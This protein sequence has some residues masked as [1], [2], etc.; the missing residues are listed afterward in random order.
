MYKHRITKWGFDRKYRKR[1]D[2]PS[3]PNKP[4][5]RKHFADGVSPTASH[6]SSPYSVDGDSST[7]PNSA[8][9]TNWSPRE[10]ST[11]AVLSALQFSGELEHAICRYF[12][13]SFQSRMWVS[14]G[15]GTACRSVKAP[16]NIVDMILRFKHDV[17]FASNYIRHEGTRYGF[18]YLHHGSEKIEG[19]VSAES[20][21]LIADVIEISLLLIKQ[22]RYD[23]VRI[24]LQQ[25]ADM[26]DILKSRSRSHTI[27]RILAQKSKLDALAFEGAALNAWRAIAAC[28]CRELG[29]LHVNTL[30]CYT[31][32]L[33]YFASTSVCAR[34][35]CPTKCDHAKYAE[36]VL[37]SHLLG[38][39]NAYGLVST[40]SMMVLEA[41]VHVCLVRQNYLAAYVLCHE[42]ICCKQ[43][44][45]QNRMLFMALQSISEAKSAQQKSGQADDSLKKLVD[46][47]AW[48][49]NSS[50]AI[51][52][53]TLLLDFL[54]N[55]NK[56]GE[57]ASIE[58][59]RSNDP[60]E[61]IRS[62][63]KWLSRS[64][65]RMVGQGRFRY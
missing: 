55:T 4:A 65:D 63:Y 5:S 25:F 57:A 49:R 43:T 40:Q 41:L 32:W 22:D 53:M 23:V 54:N 21:R 20:P 51:Y 19:L 13:T 28:F 24:F 14:D 33:M 6:G 37:R 45:Q 17:V 9:G 29:P 18:L 52:H 62:L 11:A 46:I 27:Y 48:G 50:K 64:K 56:P 10:G 47:L 2:N 34:Q 31:N 60:P 12:H 16:P 39:H 59:D 44:D 30:C 8:E 7:R 15:E 35:V 26:S 36:S 1:S 38:C 42:I 58:A 61:Q 3:W